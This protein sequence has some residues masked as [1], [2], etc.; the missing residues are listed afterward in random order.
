MHEREV[1]SCCTRSF[2]EPFKVA[3]TLSKSE[4]MHLRKWS[5][6]FLKAGQGK[7]TCAKNCKYH[8]LTKY[9]DP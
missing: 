6:G 3:F 5:D 9:I 1:A 2:M 4:L 7:P 8:W